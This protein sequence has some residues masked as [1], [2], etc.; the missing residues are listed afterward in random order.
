MKTAHSA[1][2]SSFWK[3]HKVPPLT[4]SGDQHLVT[5]P[6]LAARNS[7]KYGL[8]S[9]PTLCQAT[10]QSSYSKDKQDHGNCGS[11]SSFSLRKHPDGYPE[12]A[13]KSVFGSGLQ[14]AFLKMQVILGVSSTECIWG[15]DGR[16]KQDY[17]I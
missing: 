14:S 5:E 1:F 11:T 2:R 6:C 17:M 16:H 12:L 4:T 15:S 7:G 3:L 8:H 9:R 10:K 13:G